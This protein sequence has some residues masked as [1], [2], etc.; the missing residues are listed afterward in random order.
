M[1]LS[2]AQILATFTDVM[3]AHLFTSK[4]KNSKRTTCMPNKDLRGEIKQLMGSM[5]M[6]LHRL[7]AMQTIDL[8][9][10]DL[11]FSAKVAERD[12]TMNIP[13]QDLKQAHKSIARLAGKVADADGP[14]LEDYTMPNTSAPTKASRDKKAARDAAEMAEASPARLGVVHAQKLA[15]LDPTGGLNWMYSTLHHPSDVL[16]DDRV[17]MAI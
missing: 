15:K 16:S 3:K 8:W 6:H 1:G 17:Q 2:D 4:S 7:L 14:D 12:P 11:F 5:N 10:H 13:L 9:F